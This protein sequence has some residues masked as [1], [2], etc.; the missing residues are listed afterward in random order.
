MLKISVVSNWEIENL[1]NLQYSVLYKE[2]KNEKKM[3]KFCQ[4]LNN[5]GT[6]WEKSD[7]VF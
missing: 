7:I 3:A 4:A 6:K 2:L 1:F 5:L